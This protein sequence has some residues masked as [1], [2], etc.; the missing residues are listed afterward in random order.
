MCRERRFRRRSFLQ[1][2]ILMN[3]KPYQWLE[4]ALDPGIRKSDQFLMRAP[5]AQERLYENL[6]DPPRGTDFNVLP[7][8]VRAF[9]TYFANRVPHPGEDAIR[10]RRLMRSAGIGCQLLGG[11]LFLHA[12]GRADSAHFFPPLVFVL[13]PLL[14]LAMGTLLYTLPASFPPLIADH[15]SRA[16]IQEALDNL[17]F[18][19]WRCKFPKLDFSF[20]TAILLLTYVYGNHLGL[21]EV[22]RQYAIRHGDIDGITGAYR[23]VSYA[24]FHETW[25]HLLGN[26]SALAVAWSGVRIFAGAGRTYLLMA[27]SLVGAAVTCAVISP[28]P[29]VGFSGAVFGFIAYGSCQMLGLWRE[30]PRTALAL[31]LGFGWAVTMPTFYLPGVSVAAHVGG[32]LAGVI[33]YATERSMSRAEHSPGS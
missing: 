20:I 13:P 19:V 12:F 7:T 26:L 18:T 11:F 21:P 5:E 27:V 2:Q 33:V 23:I 24:L 31:Y 4:A 3:T 1:K 16:F 25:M 22:H 29:V 8:K 30:V 17:F 9:A 14:I 32:A 15:P 10:S 28:E 6:A